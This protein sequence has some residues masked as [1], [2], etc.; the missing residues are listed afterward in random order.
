MIQ[1]IQSLYMLLTAVLMAFAAFKPLAH[2]TI[3]SDVSDLF[4]YDLIYLEILVVISALLPFVMIWLFKDLLT[5]MRLCFAELVLLVG[6]QA[7][8]I[9]YLKRI[10]NG[11]LAHYSSADVFVNMTTPVV[12]PAVGIV[13][14]LLAVRALSKDF[15][16]I[17]SLNR[18][19]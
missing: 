3:G 17:N 4:A 10:E 19:R 2:I 12:F 6:T 18:I 11:V 16:K 5:Q 7:F 13:L 15:K 9:V 14:M 1:R 8:F